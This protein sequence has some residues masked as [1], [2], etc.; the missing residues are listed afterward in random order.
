MIK[1]DGSYKE[2]GGQIIRTALAISVI[3]GKPFTAVKIRKARKQPGLKSQHMFGIRA[4]KELCGADVVGDEIGSSSL[5]FIPKN[6][7]IVNLDIDIKT[8]GSVTLL[9]QS[10]LLPCMFGDKI[11]TIKVKGGTDT[12]WAMPIDYFSNVLVP[13][14]RRYA[15]IDVSL[16]K[17]GYYPKGDGNIRIKIRPKYHILDYQTFEDFYKDLYKAGKKINLEKQGK[18]IEIRGIS[19]ASKELLKAKV[20][21]RQAKAAEFFLRQFDVPIDIRIENTETKSIGSG[22][23]LWAIYAKDPEIDFSL[24]PIVLGA[25]ALGERG[26]RSE[27]IGQKAA[28]ALIGE[29]KK[30]TPV[31][32]YLGD[33][34]LPLM[35][36]FPDSD[37][38]V[39]EITDHAKAN[40]YVIEK[41][42]PVKFEI[43]GNVIKCKKVKKKK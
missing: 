18:L 6:T 33:Q 5:D 36:M 27:L 43:E 32:K 9:L 23:T 20:A 38:K 31:D 4:A 39:S 1:I 14:L 42:L 11:V 37:I 24:D 30:G 34:L 7:N 21:E 40:M 8:A 13:H 17:R 3:T 35:A 26:K 29:M 41:F 15:D 2:G 22:I 19:H 12:K 28:K 25:D 10:V 16:E